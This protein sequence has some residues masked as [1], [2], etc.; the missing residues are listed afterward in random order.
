MRRISLLALLLCLLPAAANA[1]TYFYGG[2]SAGLF[3]R[4][5][6][7]AQVDAVYVAPSS[8]HYFASMRQVAPRGSSVPDHALPLTIV[9]AAR[10]G[11]CISRPTRLRGIQMVHP[12]L[13]T[14]L[15]RIFFVSPAGKHLKTEQV[16]IAGL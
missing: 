15:V 2:S 10:P 7:M 13:N 14:N 5:S 16:A 9:V 6:A 8:C 4:R 3:G 11:P 1:G 12:D